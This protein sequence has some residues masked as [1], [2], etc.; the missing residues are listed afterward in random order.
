MT[1]PVNPDDPRLRFVSLDKATEPKDGLCMVYKDRWWSVHPD[2][3]I[4][5]WR[6][7]GPQCNS[8]EE[9]SRRHTARLYPWATSIFIPYVFEREY[10]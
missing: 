5:F 8:N 4:I 7:D 1:E 10:I 6:G 2:R 9:V 3:G